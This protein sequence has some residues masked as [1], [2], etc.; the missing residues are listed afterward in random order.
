VKAR[1]LDYG[2]IN[3]YLKPENGDEGID[4]HIATYQYFKNLNKT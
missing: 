1:S 4:T 2:R 3:E